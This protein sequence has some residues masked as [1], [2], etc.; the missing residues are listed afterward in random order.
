MIRQNEIE[1]IIRL[2]NNGFDINLLAFELDIPIEQL[3]NYE[4]QLKLRRF[5]KESLKNGNIPSAIKKLN[6]F[7]DSTDNNIVERVMLL[8]LKAYADRISVSEEDLQEIESEKKEIGF[9]RDID[10]ILNELQV[11]I[12]RRK[13]SNLKKKTKQ[14]L[15]VEQ[16]SEPLIEEETDEE[17]IIMPDYEEI[18]NKYKREIEENPNK[19]LNKRNLLAFAYYRAGRI[20]EARDELLSLIEQLSSYTA[21]RQLINLE[22]NEGNLDDAKLWAYDAIDKFPD[23]IDIREQLISIAR[24]EKDDKEIIT[25]LK[26]I[27]ELDP[28]EER[29]KKRL[30]TISEIEER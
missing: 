13:S 21:Y 3:E 27:M 4:K 26:E 24:A 6:D 20:E 25:L 15:S 19:S 22:K 2:I 8:K 18:I 30:K 7:I 16:E 29:N 1:E 12:P 23:S 10:E 17:E 28:N 11:Q 14:E 5:V 9:S